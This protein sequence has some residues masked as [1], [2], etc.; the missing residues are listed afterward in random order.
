MAARLGSAARMAATSALRSTAAVAVAVAVDGEQHRRL[1]LAEPVDHAAR[2]ELRRAARPD[3]AEGRGGEERRWR[4]RA[5][6]AGTRPPGRRARRRGAPGRR[7][8]VPPRRAAR[9]AV[10]VD[11][12]RVCERADDHHVVVAA[13]RRAAGSARPS[14]AAPRETTRAGHASLGQGRSRAAT[15]TG[16]RS[17]PTPMTRSRRGRRSTSA[18]APR[19]RRSG[20]RARPRARQVRADSGPLA[21]VRGGLQRTGG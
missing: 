10:S 6:S 17:D 12:S 21:R 2:P 11:P 15:R 3:G 7:A 5:R 4:P 18:A 16:P 14:S 8:R 20:A 13:A 9:A 19:S 1:D